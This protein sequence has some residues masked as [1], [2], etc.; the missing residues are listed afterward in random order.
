MTEA[1]EE[2][3]PKK[4]RVV[5]ALGKRKK[6]I[7]R[8]AIREG[9]GNVRINKKSLDNMEPRYLRLRL[10]EPI[11]IAGD[12]AKG[13]DI[14][15]NVKGGGMWG[16]ADASRT[17]IANALVAWHKSDAL[18]YAYLDYDKSLMVS[19][20]RRTEPHKPSRST[21]GPRRSKQQSK[22]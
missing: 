1:Q 11:I 3:K 9:T 21:A 2:Q 8:A 10:K 18:K 17:A 19:D 20:S 13:V 5:A 15:V 22:R 4:K 12:M 6:A 14:D 7:A 16:Q